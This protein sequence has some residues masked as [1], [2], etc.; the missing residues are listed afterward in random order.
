MAR[1]S[2]TR[3]VWISATGTS[4]VVVVAGTSRGWGSVP[5]EEV[6]V[7]V[8]RAVAVRVVVGRVCP[9]LTGRPA[10]ER[11]NWIAHDELVMP[12]VY[13]V[14]L[15]ARSSGS[16]PSAARSSPPRVA[17][18]CAQVPVVGISA[19]TCTAVV[20]P[21]THTKVG[22][23]TTVAPEPVHAGVPADLPGGQDHRVAGGLHQHT[24]VDVGFGLRGG[25]A[26]LDEPRRMGAQVLHD[27]GRWGVG[28]AP[29]VVYQLPSLSAYCSKSG[30]TLRM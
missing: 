22:R 18:I 20:L 5:S 28:A 15:S 4:A 8:H 19:R 30:Y 16:A 13:G 24:R 12:G 3:M 17:S 11:V 29:V 25:G 26:G 10:V 23:L 27:Q 9:A 6:Q 14:P 2:V 21:S 7:A 1:A